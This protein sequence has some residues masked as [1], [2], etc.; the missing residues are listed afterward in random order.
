[1]GLQYLLKRALNRGLNGVLNRP[2]WGT[3]CGPLPLSEVLD[4]KPTASDMP[5]F[6]VP[7]YGVF[8]H[9]KMGYIRPRL[10]AP[11]AK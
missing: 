8:G 1:M 3:G 6:G 10:W 4:F 11:T 5:Y 9:P 2:I 7:K